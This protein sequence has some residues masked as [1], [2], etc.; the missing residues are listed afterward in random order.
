[1][2]SFLESEEKKKEK[3][4]ADITDKCG[5]G[6]RKR[7]KLDKAPDEKIRLGLV[8]TCLHIFRPVTFKAHPQCDTK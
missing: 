5:D 1:M 7:A 4:N 8:C 2:V 3:V 6:L